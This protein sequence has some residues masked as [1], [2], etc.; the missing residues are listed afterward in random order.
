MAKILDLQSAK[1]ASPWN[2]GFPFSCSWSVY[3][4]YST[5]SWIC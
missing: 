3:K 1:S 5:G 4:C 2:P